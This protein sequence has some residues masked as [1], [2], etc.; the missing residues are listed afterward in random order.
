MPDFEVLDAKIAS[1]LNWIIHNTRFK[2]RVSPEEMKAQKEDRFLRGRQIAWLIYEY[3]WVIGANDSVENY[4]DLFTIVRR[5][6][7]IQ[8]FDTK[9]DEILLSMTKIPSDDILEGLFK[10]RIRESEKLKTVLEL[11]KM[12]KKAEPGFH[13][14]LTMVKWSMEQNL[15][16]KN[17]EPETE[18]TRQTPWSRIRE[19]NNVN[20][21]LLEIVGTGR[22]NGQC[23]KGDKLQFPT[24][25]E[26]AWKSYTI[27]SFSEFFHAAEWAKIIDNPKSQRQ[28]P[29]GRTSRWSC[30]DFLKRNLQQLNL[31]EVAPS[32]MLV[33][34]DQEWLQM[35]VK[36]TPMR[37]ARL[38]NSPA[39]GQKRMVTKFQLATLKNTQ[40]LGCVFLDMEPPKSSSILRKS[41]DIRKPIRRV[42][43][44]RAVARH[45]E[46]FETKTH[47]LEWF[48][49]V[50]FICATPMLQ[51]LRI[52]LR[53]RR[54]GKRDVPVKQRGS[55]PKVYQIWRRKIQQHSSHLRKRGSCCA[56]NPWTWGKMSADSMEC[57]TYLRNV[58]NLLPDEKTPNERRF[59][60]PFKGPIIP[61]G[62]LVEYY[63]ITAKDQSR[64]HQ[65][66][67]KV[68]P[69]MFLGYALY[70]GWIWKV[71]Y[72]FQALRSWRR[73]THQKTILKDSM[74]VR[75]YFPKEKGEIYLSSRRWTSE[76]FWKRSGTENIHLDTRPIRGE[77]HVDFLGESEGSLPPPH[78]SPPDAG[79]ATN[80]FCPC[81]ET[82]CTAITLNPESN[83]TRVEKNHSLFH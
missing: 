28:K 83:C 72:W 82:A 25:C 60:Q 63:P 41:S 18:I 19:Q 46:T 65:F 22:S 4:A 75:W 27:K 15:C 38:T 61:F 71:T 31:W 56:V 80:D 39:R 37:I 40:Q 10:M 44:T 8:E 79:E 2:R 69:G 34:Q 24:Q 55:W 78:D 50:I 67:K 26:Q 49:Q 30:K 43:F 45:A 32:R 21:E 68:S 66:G 57:Y 16:V 47:C 7:D 76:P 23:V 62:S 12:E 53:K 51:N 58:T 42:K 48:A 36:S 77:G 5:N 54:N 6:D 70:A 73:W 33:L 9:W 74:H 29:S 3:F 13:R 81:R 14:L 17:F 20:K 52:G 35:L 64:I 1:A 11:Y 59:G